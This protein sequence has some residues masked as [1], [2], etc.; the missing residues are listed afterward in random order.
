MAIPAKAHFC[1]IGATLPWAYVFAILSAAEHSDLHQIVLHHTDTLEDRPETRAVMNAP[2]VQLSHID[3]VALLRQAGRKHGLGEALA[4]TYQRLESP[5]ARSDM[6]RCAILYLQG[7]IY[8]DMDTITIQSLLPLLEARQ[9][10]GAEHIVWP[11]FVRAS[12]SP[13]LWARSLGLGL[14]R[15]PMRYVA[16]GWKLFK[17]VEHLYYHGINGAVMGAEANAPLLTDY[18]FAIA[19][20]PSRQQAQPNALGPNLL[21]KII[22]DGD[23]DDLVIHPPDVFYPMPPEISEH[24]FRFRPEVDLDAVLKAESRVVHWYASVRTKS[25]VAAIDPAYVLEHRQRQ[26]YS[27]LAYAS[28]RNLSELS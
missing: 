12:Y 7:G 5:V 22:A 13:A 21:Q 24:W 17:Y 15:K 19:A 3:P 28:I 18:L 11:G 27:A 9:F 20:V 23:Y 16:N 1:W 25:R 10:V 6:L 14:L 26:L 8:L 4:A 2:G